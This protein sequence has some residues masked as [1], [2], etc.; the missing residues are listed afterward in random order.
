M[1]NSHLKENKLPLLVATF[2]LAGDSLDRGLEK[3]M[4]LLLTPGSRPFVDAWN[5]VLGTLA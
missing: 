1:I 4:Q 2:F 3:I 5:T